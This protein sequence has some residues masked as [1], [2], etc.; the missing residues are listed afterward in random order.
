MG[1]NMHSDQPELLQAE[2]SQPASDSSLPASGSSIPASEPSL[3]GALGIHAM[4]WVDDQPV[5]SHRHDFI[6]ISLVMQG[7]CLHAWQGVEV[8]LVPGD[9][10][11]IAPGEEHAYRIE[12]ETTI[13]NCLFLPS[14][15]GSDWDRLQE[16]P[17]LEHLLVLEP[18]Y[19][20]E[21]GRQEILHLDRPEA[22]SLERIWLD[23]VH[24]CTA[25]P[26]GHALA[27]KALLMLL[28][29]RIARAW[30][31][32]HPAT[33]TFHDARRNLLALAVA[34]IDSHVAEAVSLEDLAARCYV[35]PG[36]FRKRF[37]ETTGL[38]PLE[39]INRRRVAM[40]QELLKQRDLTIAE[41]AGRVGVPDSNY[42]SRLFRQLVGVTPTAYRRRMGKPV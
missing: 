34:H 26:A 11:V 21:T 40:A 5:P 27:R 31:R 39:Y 20:E 2:P 35:S 37:R 36:H 6:E 3:P 7:S 38:S 41:V 16:D 10:F 14:G 22:D 42:F 4:R 8:R 19:R 32:I 30:T 28:L 17:A 13:Y 25:C 9:L 29:V 33:A 18:F 23:M 1:S 12:G 15:L 24:E